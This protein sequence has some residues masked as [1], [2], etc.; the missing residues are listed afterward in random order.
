MSRNFSG[1]FLSNFH[2][3]REHGQLEV[4]VSGQCSGNS[5]DNY[6][7]FIVYKFLEL[8]VETISQNILTFTGFLLE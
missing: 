7:P 3:I 5:S 8:H 4:T 2:L 1:V 6:C